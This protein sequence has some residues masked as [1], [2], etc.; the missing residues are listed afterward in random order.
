MQNVLRS[1]IQ[2]E[3]RDP[4]KIASFLCVCVHDWPGY[5]QWI[6]SS[7][8]PIS[9]SIWEKLLFI[10]HEKL[11]WSVFSRNVQYK[12]ENLETVTEREKETEKT[13]SIFREIFFHL[14]VH[15]HMFIGHDSPCSAA[16]LCKRKHTQYTKQYD[17]TR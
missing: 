15:L 16:V 1:P 8:P 11:C 9:F 3:Q 7:P 6:P 14:N 2:T 5:V 4:I 12:I 10:A 13:R 17:T